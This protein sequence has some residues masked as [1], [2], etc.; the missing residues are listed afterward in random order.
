MVDRDHHQGE[1]SNMIRAPM[2][3]TLTKVNVKVHDK[4]KKG[5]YIYLD[6]HVG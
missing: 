1:E 3:C 2:P 4:I 5:I 6:H